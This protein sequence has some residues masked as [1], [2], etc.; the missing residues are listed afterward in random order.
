MK[1]KSTRC[2]HPKCGS[3][4]LRAYVRPVSQDHIQKLEPVGWWCPDCKQYVND[5]AMP[6]THYNSVVQCSQPDRIYLSM[7]E[8]QEPLSLSTEQ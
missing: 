6:A 1:Q 8:L 5:A 4:M 7:A 3:R 2:P